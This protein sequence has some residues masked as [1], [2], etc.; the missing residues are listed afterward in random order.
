MFFAEAVP[1]H[2]NCGAGELVGTGLTGTLVEIC[3]TA[4]EALV[5]TR[6]VRESQVLLVFARGFGGL[7][8]FLAFPQVRCY[9]RVSIFIAFWSLLTLLTGLVAIVLAWQGT[10]KQPPGRQIIAALAF[11]WALHAAFAI[12]QALMYGW[13]AIVR[14]DVASRR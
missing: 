6:L 3:E 10:W 11:Y 2:L 1:A 7:F 12:A 13:P 4:P 9:N 5:D 8:N 14:S